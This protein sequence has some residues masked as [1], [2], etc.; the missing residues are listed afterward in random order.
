M[1]A[2]LPEVPRSPSNHFANFLLA[3]MGEEQCRSS[4]AV[5]GPLSQVMVL[6]VMAQRLNEPLKF[7]RSSRRITNNDRADMLLGRP[8]TS[9]RLGT[10]LPGCSR[11]G[12]PPVLTL[13]QT[14]SDA[15]NR[16]S[17]LHVPQRS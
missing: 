5:A 8:G 16:L 13:T 7:D 15:R 11:T 1:K 2:S 17:V 9:E 12:V 4:F 6:G 14:G 10:V 3:C